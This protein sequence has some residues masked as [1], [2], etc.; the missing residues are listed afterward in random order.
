MD[1]KFQAHHTALKIL[2]QRCEYLQQRL[3]SLEEENYQLK[4][5]KMPVRDSSYN[6]CLEEQIILLNKQNNRMSHQIQ[7]VTTE[8]QNLWSQLSILMTGNDNL[9]NT[10][11]VSAVQNN[12]FQ[13][14]NKSI[15]Q[16]STLLDD[17][18]KES[19]EEISLKL[20]NGIIIG[21]TELESQYSQM[22]D[23]QKESNFPDGKGFSRLP[24]NF[25]CSATMS[26]F[27]VSIQKMK[28]FRDLLL[29]QK[30]DLSNA[31]TNIK[32]L[33]LNFA[34]KLKT[35]NISHSKKIEEPKLDIYIDSVPSNSNKDLNA[36]QS[37]E[38]VK[39]CPMC[40]KSFTGS[41]SIFY[42]HVTSHFEDANDVLHSGS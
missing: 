2:R 30:I 29:Q 31:I 14:P 25:D 28:G 42:D 41:F 13:A 24:S 34:H 21:K 22:I 39:I 36:E 19:L 40:A 23:L 16:V 4:M 32:A 26:V 17:C 10:L 20:L 5:Q 18:S 1:S 9:G 35:D 3:D 6:N 27:Q 12:E 7:M 15:D 33:P 37:S 8:N 38:S 11:R